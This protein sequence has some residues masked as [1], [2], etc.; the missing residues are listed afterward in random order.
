MREHC[1]KGVVDQAV[2]EILKGNG[3]SKWERDE[4][5]RKSRSGNVS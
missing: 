2:G 4:I 5:R 1:L 3:K